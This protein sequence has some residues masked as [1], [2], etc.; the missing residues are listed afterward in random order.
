[1]KG[2][3]LTELPEI[4]SDYFREII[5]YTV[6]ELL[7]IHAS[8][9][10]EELEEIHSETTEYLIESRI[11]EEY[12]IDIASRRIYDRWA[13]ENHELAELWKQTALNASKH[14]EYPDAIA[15]NTVRAFKENFMMEN[16]NENV[17][18]VETLTLKC[19]KTGEYCK[20]DCSGICKESY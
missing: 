20:H 14:S 3:L 6:K 5:V 12:I 1:M 19:Y 16:E 9:T 4:D 8:F 15:D 10:D 13:K 18:A 17:K 7:K 2:K 11:K